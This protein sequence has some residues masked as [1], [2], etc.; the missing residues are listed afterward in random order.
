[1]K[2]WALSDLHQE[3]VRD[4]DLFTNAQTAFDPA[5]NTPAD[6]DVVVLAGD[7]DVALDNSL[8]WV[9]D[10]FLGVPTIYVPGNHDFYVEAGDADQFTMHEMMARGRELADR[11][12]VLLLMNDTAIIGD[13]RFVG[14]TLWTDFVSIGTGHPRSKEHE[15]A[16]RNGM[17]DYRRIKRS[18]T[19]D[20][21]KRKRVRPEDTIREHAISRVYIERILAEDHAG[22]TVVVTHHAP[23]PNSLDPRFTQLNYCYASNLQLLIEETQPEL[24]L[25]GHIHQAVDYEVGS[26]R[27]VSN[28][29]GYQFD[30][31]DQN[32]GFD[33]GLVIEIGGYVPKPPGM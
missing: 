7:I 27:I 18:S 21:A 13:T 33:P 17:N 24:W 31:S 23:H 4:A 8:R 19:A 1:M 14:A 12:G 10:R 2:I 3:F 29:R 25:H 16:G 32:N 5:D 9:A 20:P 30:P 22:S 15:A 26:T 11:L 28:P 6:F